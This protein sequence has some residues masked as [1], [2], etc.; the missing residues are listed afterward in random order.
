VQQEPVEAEDICLVSSL[1]CKTEHPDTF[2]SSSFFRSFP[3]EPLT[4]RNPSLLSLI[5]LRS[6]FNCPVR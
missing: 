6:G 2:F 5:L 3:A 1:P 4:F